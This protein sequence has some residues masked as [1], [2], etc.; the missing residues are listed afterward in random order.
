MEQIIEMRIL[1]PL[2]CNLIKLIIGRLVTR[3]LNMTSN[4]INTLMGFD[5][6]NYC[7]YEYKAKST[8]KNKTEK[9]TDNTLS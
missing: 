1:F 9:D 3:Y 5:H 8:I 6:N 2:L 4:K 7:Y